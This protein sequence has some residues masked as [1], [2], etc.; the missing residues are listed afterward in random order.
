M[1]FDVFRHYLT[2]GNRRS[3][4][5]NPLETS[6]AGDYVSRLRRLERI[7][8]ISLE[9]APS[10]VLRTLAEDLRQDP[11]VVAAGVPRAVAGDIVVALRAYASFL[12]DS[13]F[14]PDSDQSQPG[15]VS[16]NDRFVA[17]LAAR[18]FRLQPTA[19]GELVEFGN[20]AIIL[21]VRV[22]H[23]LFVVVHPAF[24]E[25]LSTLTSI[26]G[27]VHAT[28]G[29]FFNNRSMSKFPMHGSDDG[30]VGYGIA[31]RVF[32]DTALSHFIDALQDG[33]ELA[34]PAE[35]GKTLRAQ[36]EEPET[37]AISETRSRIGQ[38]RFRANLLEFW[39]GR[40]ALTHVPAPELLRASHIKPWRESSGKERLDMF[41]GLLLAVHL[42][43]LFDRMLIS[44][45]QAGTMLVAERLSEQELHVFG[46]RR[47]IPKLL[48]NGRHLAYIQ[49]HRDRFHALEQKYR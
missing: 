4:T 8:Q 9:N 14:D 5:G 49:H 47:P 44:F 30:I 43:A 19:S 31:F 16:H 45:D 13:A 15:E 28:R 34:N 10:L 29:L 46:L 2:S 17:L 27:V 24:V 26:A 22:S 6:T 37:E 36:L 3:F 21:Y 42:D 18:G 11:R 20:G 32:D 1:A 35:P 41:N 25:C 7:L 38:G 48:L 23:R 39:Q 33:L 12:D 40:C